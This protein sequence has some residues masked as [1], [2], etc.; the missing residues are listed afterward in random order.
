MAPPGAASPGCILGPSWVAALW[1][2]RTLP[3]SAFLSL[4]IWSGRHQSNGLVD[5]SLAFELAL[6]QR[7]NPTWTQVPGEDPSS[8]EYP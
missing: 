1:A 7:R 8:S 5:T 6:E 2:Q 3:P 4:F